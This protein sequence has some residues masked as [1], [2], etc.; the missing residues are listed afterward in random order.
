MKLKATALQDF[1]LWY[2]G[3]IA[4]HSKL[5]PFLY[6]KLKEFHALPESMKW[7]VYQEWG[8]S[9]AYYLD[10]NNVNGIKGAFVCHVN[11]VQLGYWKTRQ[12]ARSAAVNKLSDL[13]NEQK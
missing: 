8:D 7:G 2:L 11:S 10:T 6:I 12:E 9:I 5:K 3:W 4:D 1:E 13:Y